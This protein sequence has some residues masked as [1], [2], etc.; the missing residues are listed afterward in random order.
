MTRIDNN[1][2][3]YLYREKWETKKRIFLV[4]VDGAFIYTGIL[5][6]KER[7]VIISLNH[8]ISC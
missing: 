5:Q 4:S 7:N 3:K 6:N 1:K 8:T 2:Y